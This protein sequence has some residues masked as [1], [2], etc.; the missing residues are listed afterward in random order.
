MGSDNVC[1]P[2]D[3]AANCLKG[4]DVDDGMAEKIRAFRSLSEEMRRQTAGVP[5]TPSEN[6]I[7]EDR[8]SGHRDA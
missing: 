7:R 6:L 5:Q 2:E 8:D 4:C 3:E 1:R